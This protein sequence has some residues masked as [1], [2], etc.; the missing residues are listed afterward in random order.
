LPGA[1][2]GKTG[3][4]RAVIANTYTSLTAASAEIEGRSYGG[5]VLELAPTEA[6]RL[7]M[8]ANLGAALPLDECDRFVR[9]DRLN[10]VLEQ[11]DR[12]VLREIGLSASECRMLR[13]VW[14]K[15]RDRRLAR[16]RR[17][18]P[19]YSSSTFPMATYC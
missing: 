17:A 10:D 12:L 11:N 19:S 8:P 1:R 6:E 4:P 18:R 16:R 15:M 2:V 3:N 5:G 13:N 9:V 7:L 14:G